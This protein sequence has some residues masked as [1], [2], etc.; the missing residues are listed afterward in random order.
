MAKILWSNNDEDDMISCTS[1]DMDQLNIAEQLADSAN[2]GATK[3]EELVNDIPSPEV[4]SFD[5]PLQSPPPY[6]LRSGVSSLSE[7]PCTVATRSSDGHEP[8]DFGVFK[9]EPYD[10]KM[11]R[12][13]V[14]KSLWEFYTDS[15]TMES[16]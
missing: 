12:F 7:S 9:I 3:R 1:S 15:A 5:T 11:A 8:P 2:V 4:T 16:V 14:E 6:T 13:T 10:D